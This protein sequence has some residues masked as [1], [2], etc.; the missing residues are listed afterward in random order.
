M[1]ELFRVSFPDS[2]YSVRITASGY[3]ARV[4]PGVAVGTT[5][6]TGAIVLPVPLRTATPTITLSGSW[7]MSD[8]ATVLSFS[9]IGLW[10]AVTGSIWPAFSATI[11]GATTQRQYWLEAASAGSYV[12]LS[13]ELT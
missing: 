1:S 5:W 2:A 8:G 12:E 3:A 11:S 13:A 4:M 6:S 10:G 9:G 7:G